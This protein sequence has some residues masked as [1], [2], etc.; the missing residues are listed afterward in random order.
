MTTLVRRLERLRRRARAV[1]VIERTAVLLA[2]ALAVLGS[3]ILLDALARFP[4]AIRLAALFVGAGSLTLLVLRW[5]WPAV[6]F[7]PPLT[8]LALRLERHHPE[9]AGDLASSID[10]QQR[11]TSGA[12]E[13]R[14][15]SR[16][17][18]AAGR[19]RFESALRRDRLL[20]AVVGL[21][22]AVAVGAALVLA[23]PNSAGIGLR[24][25]LLPWSG[26]EWPA[27]TMVASL[28]EGVTHLPRGDAVLLRAEAVRGDPSR[29]RPFVRYRLVREGRPGPW[30]EAALAR[31][32]G[33]I[34]ERP[35]DAEAEAIEFAFGTADA[36]TA[37]ATIE[38]VPPPAVR[39]AIVTATPPEY[40][41]PFIESRRAE[42][43]SGTDARAVL[44]TPILSG[45]TVEIDFELTRPVPVPAEPEARSAW[46]RATFGSELPEGI[47]I[48]T[49]G[50]GASGDAAT[51]R[52][53]SDAHRAAPLEGRVQL[54]AQ[55]RDDL[56]L[57]V[58]LR[59]QHGIASVDNA[60]YRIGVV[61]DRAPSAS[62]TQPSA[63]EV[64]LPTATIRLVAEA[65]DDVALVDLALR[66]E[67][68]GADPREEQRRI[69]ADHGSVEWTTTPE[70]L[71]AGP[72]ETLLVFAVA[73]DGYELNG[74]RR[75][76]TV[77]PPRRIRIVGE[78][79]FTRQLRA[80][81]ASV[82]QS[83]MRA[84]ATQRDLIQAG[85]EQGEQRSPASD[86]AR[87][88][89][90]LSDRVRTMRD[91]VAALE[92]RARA[93]GLEREALG[94][95]MRQAQDLLD[96]AGEASAEA[97]A[98]LGA[99]AA[100]EAEAARAQERAAQAGPGESDAAQ[101]AAEAAAQALAEAE[102]RADAAQ[103]SQEDVRAELEDLVRLLDRD[104]D[105]WVATRRIERL[106]QD[107]ERLLEETRRVGERTV[108]RPLES[109]SAEERIE[110]ERLAGRDRVAADQARETLDELRDRAE[111]LAQADRSRAAGM[112]EAARRG[113]ERNLARR[114]DEAAEQAAQNQP[115]NSE[116][117]LREA[118]EAAQSMREAIQDDR[119][120][121]VEELRRRLASLEESVRRLVTQADA[122]LAGLRGL[123]AEPLGSEIASVASR[124]VTLDRNIGAVTD[125][126]RAG[127]GAERVARLL[128]RAGERSATAAARLRVD[129]AD[130][131]GGDDALARSRG[132]LAEALDVIREQRRQAEAQQSEERRRELAATL[133]ALSERQA[134]VRSASEP[135][136]GAAAGDRR[137]LV[138][139]RRLGVEQE[140]IRSA[141]ADLRR[142]HEEI[143]ASELFESACAR[144][145]EWMRRSAEHLTQVT[146]SE[147]TLM[148]Q[149]LAAETLAM[150]GQAL[151]DPSASDDPFAEA[152]AEAGEQGG[153]GG[154]GGEGAPQIPPI[155]EL[156]LLRETQAQLSRRTRMVDEIVVVPAE[157]T[158]ALRELA[159]LQQQLLEQGEAWAERLRQ[160]G[161]G[162]ENRNAP[163]GEGPGERGDHEP[164]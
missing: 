134:G 20:R 126:A 92:S 53:G 91:A 9:L 19:A 151:A 68:A 144:L 36:M 93:G 32:Q 6:R 160:Q 37:A 25:A 145:D 156:R 46:A 15:I 49:P 70:S 87:R 79:E 125:E 65:H 154:A 43:G 59:D 102:A 136:V 100:A 111:R 38:L 41:A 147:R 153:A 45:S 62:V 96:A 77:S 162:A 101:A 4:L 31:Q 73:S 63:D 10:F 13:S 159:L 48:I 27:R 163:E 114:L 164:Q 52:A 55:L 108:G 80:Q 104:E 155:A 39:Q 146:V 67:R 17:E 161:G 74:E 23:D 8:E 24:R 21:F 47:E 140:L 12:L 97:S 117:S 75:L 132:L 71:G 150:M 109:L 78:E 69:G 50:D 105:A 107:V 64:V 119:R 103:A 33:G 40:A 124:V 88:Q 14:T 89:A 142:D 7:N 152:M 120:S 118:L 157:R 26:A 135:L 138:E 121:R 28:M 112:Q 137:R 113:E 148:D 60:R 34:F 58:M 76:P 3:W 128:D 99:Q 35:I 129:P 116:Q 85:Q 110:I 141:V 51:P 158:E 139:S 30:R 106:V 22:F 94:E 44:A 95:I 115:T 143:A 66:V 72:G 131:V 98:Q 2:F 149:S 127:G 133:R 56:T 18:S 5:W 11:S 90:Q 57:P 83:A 29:M 122:G 86:Q 54:R 123:P 82:R 42:L 81:L 16:T 1:L 84:E 130:L 61:P